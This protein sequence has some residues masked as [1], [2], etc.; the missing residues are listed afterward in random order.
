MEEALEKLRL[1]ENFV[2]ICDKNGHAKRVSV[3]A[4][5]YKKAKDKLFRLGFSPVQIIFKNAIQLFMKNEYKSAIEELTELIML[6]PR[7]FKAYSFRAK[8]FEAAGKFDDAINDCNKALEILHT[9]WDFPSFNQH[10]INKKINEINDLLIKCE[11]KKGLSEVSVIFNSV[12][13][14]FN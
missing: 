2:F 8:A 13:H 6:N 4:S 12:H 5:S 7:S 11:T 10:N 9:K 1:Q 3:T 14:T